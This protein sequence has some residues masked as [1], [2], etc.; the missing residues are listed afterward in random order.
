MVLWSTRLSVE[1]AR[2]G[3]T[4]REGSICGI[5]AKSGMRIDQDTEVP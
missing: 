1:T 5:G 2:V 3:T 4:E